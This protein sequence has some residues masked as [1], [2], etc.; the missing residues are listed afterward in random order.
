MPPPKPR[1]SNVKLGRVVCTKVRRLHPRSFRVRSL[2]RPRCR[3][4]CCD[5]RASLIVSPA[6]AA[7]RATHIKARPPA[8]LKSVRRRR[9]NFFTGGSEGSRRRCGGEASLFLSLSPSLSLPLP[10][11]LQISLTA[12]IIWSIRCNLRSELTI[13][14]RL[15]PQLRLEIDAIAVSGDVP[16]TPMPPRRYRLLLVVV[17]S[18][19]S[20]LTRIIPNAM[21]TS[22]CQSN[23]HP[24]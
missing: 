4:R 7:R 12:S 8:G 10:L 3:D 1:R 2:L 19:R 24:H 14:A 15:H 6:V 5:W 11:S 23:G 22:P 17:A 13:Q 18:Q 21:K 16:H 20:R 9:G